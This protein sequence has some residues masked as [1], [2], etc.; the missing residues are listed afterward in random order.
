[1]SEPHSG[2]FPHPHGEQGSLTDQH[3]PL[4]VAQEFV[5]TT[6]YAVRDELENLVRRDLLGPWEGEHEQ[7]A[8]RAQGPRERYLVGMLGPKHAPKSAVDEAGDVPDTESGVQGGAEAELPDVLTPQNLGRIWAS[9]MGMTFA[10]P[11]DVDALAVTVTWGRYAKQEIED[12][13]GKSRSTWFRE[14]VTYEPDVRLDG[15]PTDRIPLTGT[16]PD[17]PCVLLAV[18]VRPRDGQRVVRLVLVN[19]QQEPERNADTGWLFQARLTATALDGNA[20]I[21]VPI[22]DPVDGG[23][24]TDDGE[25]THLRLLYRHHRRYAAGHN[26]A[27]HPHVRDGE[28]RGHKLETTWLPTYDVPSTAAAGS[29]GSAQLSMDALAEADADA[30]RQGLAPLAEGY[31]RWLDERAAEVHDL[32]PALQSTGTHAVDTARIAAKRIRAGIRLLTTPAERGHDDALAAFRFANRVMALQRRHTAIARL[33]EEQGLSYAEAYPQVQ[34]PKAATWRPFQLAFVL[35]NLPSLTDVTHEERAADPSATVDL[36]FFPTGGGKTEAYLGLAAY[37]FAIRRLQGVVGEGV[38]ARSGADGVAVLMRYTLR[39]LTA[40]QFQRAAALVCAAEVVRQEDEGTWGAAPFRI[41]LWVGGGVSPNWYPQA[42]EQIAEAKEAGKGRRVNVLQT[43]S[44][45][46]CGTALKGHQDLHP[47]EV[48]RRVFLFCPNAEGV[49][50]CPFSRTRSEEGLPVLTVDEEIYRFTPA[51][52]IATVDKLAQLPWRGFA[53]ML[54]GRVRERCPR[55][56]YRHDD[57]DARTGCAD[58]HNAKGRW[59]AVKSQPVVRLRPPDLIIQDELHLISGA[60]GTTVGLFESA[61]DELC[62]WTAPGGRETGPKIVASTATTKRAHEQVLGVFGRSLQIFPPPVLDVADTFFSRQVEVTPDEP[63]RRYLGVCAHGV[64]LKSAEIRLAEILLI[65]GQTLFDRHG[66]AADPYLTLVGYFNATRELAGMRRYLDDDVATRVRRHGRRKGL[67]DRIIG[68][69]MLEIA[70]LTSRISSADI[71]EV[72]RRLEIAFNPELDTSDRR[73][74]IGADLKAALSKGDSGSGGQRPPHA[75]SDENLARMRAGAV[76][77]DVV[78]ATSMLQVGVDVSR[79]GLMVVTGQPKNTAEYIQ[80][81]SRVGRDA[82]R[83]GLVV[84]LY[85]W[86]RPRDLAHY[87]DFEH[88]HAT[89]YRQVEALSVTPFTRRSLDRGTA[90]MLVAAVRN[91]EDAH[92]RNRDAHDVPLD[93]P[94]FARI[95][96]RMLRRAET[97]DPARGRNYLSERIKRFTDVWNRERTAGVQLG[98]ETAKGAQQLR[99]LLHRSGNGRWDDQTVG[100]SMRETENEINLLVP[101]DVSAPLYGEPDWSFAPPDGGEVR[102]PDDEDLPDGDELGDTALTGKAGR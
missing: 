48:A 14:P 66:A 40:Q 17:E 8:P 42:E 87:E 60:L 92:S 5:Q 65:A 54:F 41:G 16:H 83:P 70:E 80:A 88:Y 90:G 50:A 96:E 78:L 84:T 32:P 71:S 56:G 100:M 38:D 34:N 46:W 79:F 98:Y 22:D 89:F 20:A 99:G 24:S 10:V 33:R 47:D 45:P 7:F 82:K 4:D 55:H 31:A 72:L 52:V 73:R 2:L 53:G 94:V 23:A 25:E 101:A 63:G 74:A 67:S 77:V 51:L 19:A 64:R 61:V 102:P 39:L 43:L 21:F 75:I 49:D 37:T 9:S 15:R 6:S 3:D 97:V 69:R 30:L 95:V 62:T 1:M 28:R 58:R 11:D 59:P 44:C 57:L 36:L 35:L 76:P 13:D 86:S 26:V 85:N 18:D 12:A 68:S 81:S 27:V 91:A 93:G 29:V